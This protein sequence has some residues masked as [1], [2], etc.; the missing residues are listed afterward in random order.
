[1]LAYFSMKKTII[2]MALVFSSSAAFAC[3][4]SDGAT[5]TNE[6]KADKKDSD[7]TADKSQADKAAKEKA[8]GDKSTSPAP[9]GAGK[10]SKKSS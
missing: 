3:P 10:D 8:A 5:A 4:H 7:K 6:K 2:A 1:M 9:A